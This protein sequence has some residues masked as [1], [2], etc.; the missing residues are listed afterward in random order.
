MSDFWEKYKDPRWQRR[1]LEI[2]HNADFSCEGCGSKSSTLNVHHKLYR[3]GFNPWDYNN[4]ELMCLCED[5]HEAWH[6]MKEHLNVSLQFIDLEAYKEVVG[7]AVGVS[8]RSAYPE[9]SVHFKSESGMTG[10][11]RA[12]RLTDAELK[13]ACGVDGFV[14]AGTLQVL[15]QS[16]TKIRRRG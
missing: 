4:L 13:K 14:T 5:C 11:A 10:A 9:V 6:L 16:K 12:L 15:Y 1:R 3:K 7:Y 2:M 8:L